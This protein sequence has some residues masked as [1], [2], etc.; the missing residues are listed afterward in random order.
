MKG[1]TADLGTDADADTMYGWLLRWMPLLEDPAP[2]FAAVVPASALRFAVRDLLRIEVFALD[3]T[4]AVC[5]AGD[6]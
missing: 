3:D 5:L 4:G 2:R 6:R 1:H